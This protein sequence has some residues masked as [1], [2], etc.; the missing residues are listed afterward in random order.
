MAKKKEKKD[1]LSGDSEVIEIIQKLEDSKKD[2][3]TQ[4]MLDKI[5]GQIELYK[6]LL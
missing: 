4:S 6:K 5:D 3:E 2:H 1:K